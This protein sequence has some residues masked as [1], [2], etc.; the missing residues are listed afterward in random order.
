MPSTRN[1]RSAA[2]AG[3]ALRHRLTLVVAGAGWGKS[4]LLRELAT[5]APSIVLTRPPSGWTPLTMARALLDG[6]VDGTGAHDT[7]P[8]YASPDTAERDEQAAALAARACETAAELLAV[9][10]LVVID[11]AEWAADDPLNVF[12]ETLVRHVPPRLHLVIAAR[13]APELRIARLRAAGE[14]ARVGSEQ[15]AYTRD[16]LDSLGVTPAEA[17]AVEAI[18]EATHGWPLAVQLAT[19][20]SRRSGA[21]LDLTALV[22]RLLSP[23]AVLF[24][25]LASD[26]AAGFSPAERELLAVICRTPSLS[27]SV[28][29]A[30]GRN[31]LVDPLARLAADGVFAEPVP[32]RQGEVQPTYLGAEFIRRALPAPPAELLERIALGFVAHGD[33]DSA[34]ELCTVVRSADLAV[35]VLLAINSPHLVR[36]PQA[37]ADAIAIAETGPAHPH[38]AELRGDVHYRTGTWDDALAAYAA[39]A[40]LRAAAGE[41]TTQLLR[42]QA[43]IHYFRGDLAAADELCATASIDGSDP[44]E[45]AW[46]LAWRAVICWTRGDADAC[47]ALVAPA[48]RRAEEAGDDSATAMVY[49]AKAMLCALRG[50]LPGNLFWYERALEHAER[51]GDVLQVIRIR[52][53]RGSRLTEEG[54]YAEAVAELDR[55]IGLAELAGSDNF[56]ALAHSNRGE[57]LMALGQLDDA[58]EALRRAEAI[59][60]RLGSS[61]ILY[62]ISNLAAVQLLRG[63]RTQS[64]ALFRQAAEA[65]ESRGDAQ[66]AAQALVG[67]ARALESEHPDEAAEVIQR[68]IATQQAI[69]MPHAYVT[70]GSIALRVGDHEDA[71]RWAAR[72]VA[73]A[74]DRRDQPALAE[75]LLL[76]AALEQPPSLRLAREAGRLWHELGNRIGQ[77]RADL[78]AAQSTSGRARDELVATAERVLYDAGALG[79]LAEA[80][81][82]R[83]AAASAPV[84]VITLG[85]FRVLRAGM[86]VEVGEWGSRKARDL[87][88]LL[89]A[90]RGM[91]VR[92]D[93]VTELLWPDEPDRSPRRLSVL[94]STVRGVL[95][96][97]K[98]FA[99]EHFVDADPD[100]I[101]LVRDHVELDLELFIAEAA[102]GRRLL[103]AGD[104]D[105]AH[106]VLAGAAARYV[107]EFC[108]DDPFADWLAGARELAK[109]TFVDTSF[110]L[111]RL[112]DAAGEHSEAIRHWLRVIDVDPYDEDAHLGM[113]RSLL[114][115]RRHGEARRAYRTYCGRLGELSIE[116]APFPG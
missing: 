78:L 12:V 62:A 115:Q 30:V 91:P 42:R 25:Y 79:L 1:E 70:A 20:L 89:I 39:A 108:A 4:T 87:L 86:P 106:D 73:S 92:R 48:E 3:H 35:Q 105:K 82:A 37:L 102:E 51:A 24:D 23:D 65:A 7:L 85:G 29:D 99:P 96:P 90:R 116:P 22:D 41:P 113:I 11:D 84:T 26:V 40:Q 54:R 110:E 93:E 67:L 6:L 18:I 47:A 13:F 46:V 59:W 5:A 49:T 114:L 64:I 14:V 94:L 100:T 103:A 71:A 21:A 88:K 2:L 27:P 53:N 16:D 36:S 33:V 69:W 50:D 75:A 112:A 32:G 76:Q 10:T 52:T 68:A 77:A 15:L 43:A 72:A 109:H 101:W 61:R 55:A 104:R 58:L 97:D 19:D 45:E 111:A 57:A 28:L 107:G 74:N 80:R 56:A 8:R 9:D 38:I 17:P 31:D 34:L 83:A 63:Q 66:G 95:D 81:Q 44:G 98:L 60:M